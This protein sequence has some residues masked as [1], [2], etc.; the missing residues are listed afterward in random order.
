[1]LD[2]SRDDYSAR[3]AVRQAHEYLKKHRIQPLLEGLL[4]RAALERPPDLRQFLIKSLQDLKNP[5][6]TP[7]M[8]LMTIEDIQTMYDMWSEVSIGEVSISRV[9]STLETLQCG[10]GACETVKELVGPECT[11]VNKETFTKIV[12][13]HLKKALSVGYLP[14]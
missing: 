9:Y 6:T 8:S 10:E 2:L 4:A 3:P 14:E 12:S 11:N 1:V 13:S 7:T 5:E